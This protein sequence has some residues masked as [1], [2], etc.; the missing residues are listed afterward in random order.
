MLKYITIL[1]FFFS[2]NTYA[3]SINDLYR[4]IEYDFSLA[5]NNL[6]NTLKFEKLPNQESTYFFVKEKKVS[7]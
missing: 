7:K 5:E 1:F 2:I 4:F 6:V 3:Q